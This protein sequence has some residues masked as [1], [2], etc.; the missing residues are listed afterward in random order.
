VIF[1]HVYISFVNGARGTNDIVQRKKE[2]E[3]RALLGLIV[4]VG[5]EEKVLSER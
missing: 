4:A 2:K 5:L 1:S 3:M